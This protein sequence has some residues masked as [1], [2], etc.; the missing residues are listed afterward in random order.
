MSTDSGEP[1]SIVCGV[2]SSPHAAAVAALAATLAERLGLRVRF[3]HSPSADV[4]VVGERRR[5]TIA[6]GTALLAAFGTG[7]DERIVR[8]GPPADVLAHAITDDTAFAVVGSRGHGAA[9]AALLGS[10]SRALAACAPC[11]LIVVPPKAHVELTAEPTIVCGLDGSTAAIDALRSA[12]E[13]A[14]GLG[15][16][17]LA[18]H[19]RAA[20]PTQLAPS[21]GG[22]RQPFVEPLDAARAAVAI[23]ERPVAELD[24]A[25]ATT[26]RIESGDA[27]AGLA[28]VAAEAGHGILVVGSHRHG[29][30]RSALLGSVSLRLAATAPVPVMVVPPTSVPTGDRAPRAGGLAEHVST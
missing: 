5:A 15:G 1:G 10:V 16:H 6:R 19:V 11:P 20:T 3:V 7:R 8:L 29:L 25:V 24:P 22:P 4:F 28:H 14:H 17:L 23:V 2:D 18:V 13:L 27:A 12:A 26:M 30:L 21:I 9:R